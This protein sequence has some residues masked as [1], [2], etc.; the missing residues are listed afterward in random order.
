M[1]I[2]VLPDSARRY[3]HHRRRLL[4][5]ERLAGPG[6]AF[7]VAYQ[8]ALQ[9]HESAIAAIVGRAA[10]PDGPTGRLLRVSLANYL[11]AAVMMPYDAF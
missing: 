6:R 1:P 11:A 3:D 4:L 8:L 7:A 9:E 2:E 5:S 10:P